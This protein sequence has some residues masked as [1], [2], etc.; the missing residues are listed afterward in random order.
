MVS[1]VT[2]HLTARSD[3]YG[4]GVVLLEILTGKKAV[5]KSRPAR[6]QNLVDWARP[7]LPHS[8]KLPKIMDPRIEGQYSSTVATEVA[9]LALRCLSQNPKGRP[10][11]NQVVDTLESVQDPHG[12]REEVL[13]LFEAP[14]ASSSDSS[15]AKKGEEN[16]RRSKRGKGRSKSEPPADFN[17]S[18]CS[19]DADGQSHQRMKSAGPPVD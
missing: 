3:V 12:S 10:T 9:G 8:R 14:K 19:P 17:V 6:E 5:D 18:S 11:M 15:S 2:G 16:R 4:F 1:F 13:L 7:L